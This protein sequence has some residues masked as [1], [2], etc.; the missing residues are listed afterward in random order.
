MKISYMMIYITSIS[1][2]QVVVYC[3]GCCCSWS[4]SLP[5]Y[6][7]SWLDRAVVCGIPAMC[8][9]LAPKING[10]RRALFLYG[11]VRL[12]VFGLVYRLQLIALMAYR[13]CATTGYHLWLRSLW[14]SAQYLLHF[15]NSSR[16][17][18]IILTLQRP[19]T[20]IFSYQIEKKAHTNAK[21][22]KTPDQRTKFCSSVM[23]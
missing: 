18:L 23:K 16:A 8:R 12:L 21:K 14:N 4:I 11:I 1:I 9:F 13:Q 22:I 19:Q 15:H 3:L 6:G 17:H 5:A 7:R 20:H 2:Q 10:V